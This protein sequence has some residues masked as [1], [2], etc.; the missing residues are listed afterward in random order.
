ML[1]AAHDGVVGI[2]HLGADSRRE[3]GEIQR[4]HA[5]LA[6]VAVGDELVP[7]REDDVLGSAG[8]VE[9]P[10]SPAAA[11]GG[12]LPIGYRHGLHVGGV[13]GLLVDE[14][15]SRLLIFCTHVRY[16]HGLHVGGVGGLLVDELIRRLL[17][18]CTHVRL[19]T[20]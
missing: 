1:P 11:V 7:T 4:P 14:R 13:G 12:I 19:G 18:F 2:E 5:V 3:D 15:L 6:V 17:I 20:S 8:A 16:R 9:E 10:L